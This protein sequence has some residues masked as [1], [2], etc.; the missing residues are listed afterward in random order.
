MTY[1]IGGN[2]M[3]RRYE[4]MEREY[5]NHFRNL[6][7]YGDPYGLK[8]P[9]TP[10]LAAISDCQKLPHCCF[11]ALANGFKMGSLVGF[12]AMEL[13]L[14]LLEDLDLTGFPQRRLEDSSQGYGS[15]EKADSLVWDMIVATRYEADDEEMEE[16]M[17]D[18]VSEANEE[19]MEEEMEDEVSEADDEEMEEEMEDEVSKADDEEMEEEMEDEVSEADDEETEEEIDGETSEA[20]D[21]EV[22][23]GTDGWSEETKTTTGQQKST[24]EDLAKESKTGT[25]VRDGR[26]IE[27]EGIASEVIRFQG[28]KKGKRYG[29]GRR[30]LIYGTRPASADDE[31]V[32]ADKANAFKSIVDLYLASIRVMHPTGYLVFCKDTKH[33]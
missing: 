31:E 24:I 33:H 8:S 4:R 15:D 28:M 5:E 18:E 32:G 7:R 20:D 9:M 12:F 22:S 30:V 11:S 27:L 25:R 14:D 13:H 6:D 21:G 16:E 29:D 3:Q 26:L 23:E 10:L 2:E 19:E 17:E 1:F